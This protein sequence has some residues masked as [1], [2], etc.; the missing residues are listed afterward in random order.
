MFARML[1]RRCFSK[2]DKPQGYVRQD[3]SSRVF[4]KTWQIARRT[5]AVSAHLM[6]K[7]LEKIVH[8]RLLTCVEAGGVPSDLHYKFR[9]GR[10]I[11]KAIEWVVDIARDPIEGEIWRFGTK[12]Y[13]AIVTLDLRNPFN[14]INWGRIMKVLLNMAT[15]IYL[16]EILNNYFQYR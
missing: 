2:P 16:M 9:K 13:R 10:S 8:N 1:R 7:I 11:V 15:P 12:E 14:S 3:A 6:R 5:I 4:L